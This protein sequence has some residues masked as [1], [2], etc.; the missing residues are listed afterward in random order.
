[1]GGLT[2]ALERGSTLQKAKQSFI[3]AGYKPE[4][5]EAASK[6]VSGITSKIVSS[7]VAPVKG[8]NS[9]VSKKKVIP[10]TATSPP[11][12]KKKQISKKFTIV[13]IL[14]SVIV[15]AGLAFIGISWFN[16]L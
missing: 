1:V 15:F 12:K 8:Q 10:N 5:I 14:L 7:G 3:N 9:V 13:L 4:D 2:N 16:T 6:K 11:P